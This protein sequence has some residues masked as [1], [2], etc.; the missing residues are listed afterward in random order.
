M[1]V[2]E[3]LFELFDHKLTLLF[4]SG[5]SNFRSGKVSPQGSLLIEVLLACPLHSIRTTINDSQ[6]ILKLSNPLDQLRI[7]RGEVDR[8]NCFDIPLVE[9]ERI[10]PLAVVSF[11]AVFEL[12]AVLFDQ[13]PVA[14]YA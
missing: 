1:C 9:C 6:L 13:P 12:G 14:H 11:C 4:C 5:Q 7:F 3:P 2:F 10:V 8:L